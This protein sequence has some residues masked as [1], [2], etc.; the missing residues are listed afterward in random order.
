M[1]CINLEILNLL[2]CVNF[3]RSVFYLHLNSCSL[4]SQ[5]VC[6]VISQSILADV[7]ELMKNE[8]YLDLIFKC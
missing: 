8:K 2:N 6:T 4:K 1:L 3:Y 5:T 7:F